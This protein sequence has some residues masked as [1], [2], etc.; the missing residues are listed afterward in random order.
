VLFDTIFVMTQIEF[1]KIALIEAQKGRGFC[2]PNPAV[3]A[4]VVRND[5][6]ISQGYHHGPGC[7]HAEVEAL[8]QLD[9]KL[10][11]CDLYVTLEPCCHFGRTPPCVD[12]I[13]EH[14]LRRV[15]FAYLDP[16]PE[17]AGKGQQRLND[18][19]IECIHLP[20]DEINQSYAPYQYW[21]RYKRP[22]VKLKLA[23][24]DRHQFAIGSLTGSQ[25]QLYTHQ[26]RMISDAMLTSVNTIIHD[27]PQYN[28][29]LIDPSIKKP[30][31]IL[32]R[33]GRL[34][35]TAKIV[36]TC[37]PVILLSHSIDDKRLQE[38]ERY[39]IECFAVPLLDN[40]LDLVACL[41]IIGKQGRHTLWVESGWTTAASFIRSGCVNELLFYIAKSNAAVECQP[42]DFIYEPGFARSIEF[43][44]L[45]DDLLLHI[46]SE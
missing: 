26:Q 31:Y 40:R 19:G 15:F 34:P 23:I 4:V 46:H 36:E 28:V 21:W 38:F 3:G 32:D 12:L 13:I 11:D 17:V 29:R 27:D 14:K 42:F 33:N 18:A 45:G 9:D 24:D 1:M 25:A 30:L 41:D 39:G 43:S 2:A 10:S 44:D 7:A 8:N 20:L 35:V 37:H 16:N 5:Q 22:W 6:V